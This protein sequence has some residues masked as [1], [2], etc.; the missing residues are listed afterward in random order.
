MLTIIG[1]C[2]SERDN[3]YVLDAAIPCDFRLAVRKL[4]VTLTKEVSAAPTLECS[5]GAHKAKATVSKTDKATWV[6]DDI[7]FANKIDGDKKK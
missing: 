2:L 3:H 1:G 4:S 7:Y 5:N 6:F